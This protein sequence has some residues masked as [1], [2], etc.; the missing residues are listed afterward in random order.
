M[1]NN[2]VT[3]LVR[4]ALI[5]DIGS[6]DITTEAIVPSASRS[7]AII[8]AKSDG[9]IAGLPIAKT[10]FQQ[11]NSKIKFTA[12][13]KDGAQV[14]KGK[15]IAIL[16]GPTRAIL[17]GERVA[18]NFLQRLSGIATLTSKFKTQISKPKTNVKL[19]DTR[20]T[21]PGLRLLEKY[22]VAC[23]GGTNHR[24]G[25]YDA[26]LIKDNHIV[27][28]GGVREALEQMT[29][30]GITIEI[31]TRTLKEVKDAISGKADRILLDNMNLVKMKQAVKLCRAAKIETEASGGINLNN[32]T[33]IAKTGVN[34]ISVGAL[35][36]SSPAL[37]IS[38]EII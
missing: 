12:K 30:E 17:T 3:E 16:E 28:A 2:F 24:L 5:E 20:K 1:T 13:V 19:L 34:F 6:G 29:N 15:V 18:L 22:A 27:V 21:T 37:D 9:V 25:L 23:G 32:V 4:L 31:E 8:L 33:A 11:L 7:K 14:K 10:V 35:T 26:I 38:L 36:H